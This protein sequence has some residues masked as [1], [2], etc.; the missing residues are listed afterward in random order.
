MHLNG[1]VVINEKAM[2]NEVSFAIHGLRQGM[3][4][5]KIHTTQGV[6]VKK[7]ELF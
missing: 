6:F 4:L 7:L 2:G 5:I 1:K 3:Y